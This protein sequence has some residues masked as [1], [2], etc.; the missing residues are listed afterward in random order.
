MPATRYREIAEALRQ[1]I[2]EGEH[3]VG[4]Q[5]PSENDLAAR[6]DASRGTVRQAV[7]L[8]ASE[9]LIGSR[10]GARRIVLRQE[11]RH[12][13]ADLHSF[14][15]W[16]RRLGC[17]ASSRFLR[18]ER[19][20][21]TAEEATRL[22]LPEGAELLFVLR[23][24]H[25]DGRPT[26]V[27]R[28]A[29]PEWIAGAIE[30]L[31]EDCPSIMDSLAR[32]EGVVAHYGEHLI[33][34]IAAGSADARLLRIRRGSPLLRQRHLTSTATGRAIEWTT[35][36]YRAGSVTFSVGNSVSTA[37]LERHGGGEH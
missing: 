21:A 24:R 5:L 26:M 15:Q 32:D 37:P 19:R 10:Q 12:S 35:D 20:P 2:L 4:T 7:A 13:F 36:H 30:R 27:E 29:Y 11:R 17:E 23:L 16:A 14:A 3:P 22:S 1:A 33:D 9:G 18:R 6:W 28:T 8:L 34:A 25:L 31:P